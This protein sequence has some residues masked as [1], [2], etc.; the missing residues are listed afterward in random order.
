[1]RTVSK[2]VTKHDPDAGARTTSRHTKQGNLRVALIGNPNTGKSTVFNHLTGSHQHVGNWPGKTVEK[3]EGFC[4]RDGAEIQ[5]VDLP[6]AYSLTAYS[7]EEVVSRDYLLDEKPD[8]IVVVVDAA[9]L[10]RNLY[11]VVQVLELNVPVI[12]ALNLFDVAVSRGIEI[13]IPALNER[14][15]VRAVPTV[16]REGEGVDDLL[17]EI[18]AV[19]HSLPGGEHGPQGRDFTPA[20]GSFCSPAPDFVLDYGEEIEAEIFPLERKIAQ[21]PDVRGRF[22]QRWLAVKLLERD[23]NVAGKLEGVRGGPALVA[24]GEEGADRIRARTGEDA[25]NLLADRRYLWINGVVTDTVTKTGPEGPTLSDRID[26]I[27]THRYFG[28]PIFLFVMWAVFKLITDVS[29]PFV[30]W[31][32]ATVNG[33]IAA[34]ARDLADAVGIDGTWG[35]S[36]LVDG[37]LAGVGNVL[38]FVPIL[39]FLY[40]ML[41]LLEDS[42]YMARAAFVMDRL[43]HVLGLHGK[44]FLPL[45]VGFG[46]NVP[47]V[48]ATRVL[49]SRKDRL[50]TGL[51]LPFVTCAARLPIYI[52]LAAVFFP[53]RQSTVVF[54]MYLLSILFV[55]IVGIVLSRTLF[56]GKE[57]F[58]FV[59][60]LPPYRLPSVRSVR[61]HTWERTAGF[62]RKAGTVI[63]GCSM[64]IW[65]LLA[66]PVSGE[67]SFADTPID[68]SLF[69]GLSETVSPV[70]APAGY[71]SWELTGTLVT[72]FVA[73]EIVVSTMGQVYS[74]A[75]DTGD[76]ADDESFGEDLREIGK[77]FA[78]AGGDAILTLP[79]IIGIDLVSAEEEQDTALEAAIRSDFEEA[80]SGHGSLAAFAFMIFVLLYVPCMATVAA[81]RHEF[82]TKWMW[83]SIAINLSVAW[84]ATVL[85]FQ[86]GK[87]L[88]FS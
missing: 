63:L 61:I 57:R 11:L 55:I 17:D 16:A 45:M 69:A 78:E 44:S 5:F 34:W 62:L 51:L 6:G 37:A 86:V 26:R 76:T 80:S 75:G 10:E 3:K 46:C 7:L 52:L 24:A 85:V 65:F 13:D 82:G 84:T 73:K 18:L 4:R 81:E 8:A 19:A 1:M 33:P 9:N 67:G 43:M 59:M 29:L 42:G 41:T 50:L 20:A 88:G 79:R 2:T 31:V 36:L 22:P 25:E 68:D 49:E 64:V 30:D 74:S 32:D 27:V 58:P 14:L 56:R 15:G 54:A 40:V 48:Y 83:A 28:I 66:V 60:E 71:N 87:L 39:V 70:F 53:R 12:L 21:Y 23:E 38:V 47:A 77:G 35:E 72:G